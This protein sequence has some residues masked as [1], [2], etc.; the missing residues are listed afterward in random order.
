MPST[1]FNPTTDRLARPTQQPDEICRTVFIPWKLNQFI[2]HRQ[3][4]AVRTITNTITFPSTTVEVFCLEFISNT[5]NF[6]YIG[7]LP[8]PE[9][10]IP[11]NPIV[12]YEFDGPHFQAILNR[13]MED[14][15]LLITVSKSF[16]NNSS[17]VNSRALFLHTI[18]STPNPPNQPAY[19]T[20]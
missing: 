5:V 4:N 15:S 7:D 16:Y 11:D 19:I 14:P 6:I 1:I 2:N 13:A 12:P 18:S 3:F 9:N 20:I 10:C 8:C 17:T